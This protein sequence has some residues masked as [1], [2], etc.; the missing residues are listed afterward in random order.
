MAAHPD[1]D[2]GV[3]S[4][5]R[6]AAV[7]TRSL[8]RL[9][10]AIGMDDWV[11]LDH[12]EETS[13]GR[14]KASILANVFEA[15]LAALYLDGGL[16]PVRRLV[17][18]EF[19]ALIAEPA[20]ALRDAKT[21]LQET[22]QAAGCD[23]PPVPDDGRAGSAA[24]AR[25]PCRGHQRRPG[26]RPGGG[27]QQTRGGATRGA[28]RAHP[29]PGVGVLSADPAHRCGVVALLGRPNAG[30][31]TLLNA[32]L[33]EKLAITSA[34]AQTTRS[35]ILGVLTR[36]GVQMLFYDTPGVHRGQARFNL[37]MT[38]AALAA[39]EDAD[40][41]RTPVRD[42]GD[43]GYA[44]GAAGGALPPGAAGAHQ[45]RPGQA[46][47][48]P[49]AGALC[50]DPE[51][52]GTD[53]PRSAGAVRCN[54]RAPAA[55]SRPLSRRRADR[56]LHALPGGGADPRGRLRAA[57]RRDPLCARRRGG[58]VAGGGAGGAHT[59]E[60]AGGAGVAQGDRGRGRGGRML[61]AISAPRPGAASSDLS[62]ARPVH[63]NL[64]VKTDRNW[65]KRPKRI[66]ELGY[67]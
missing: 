63:L 28:R 4:R 23:A 62:S 40:V 2:E 38:D 26:D 55:R 52:L 30:K 37:A 51:R 14:S 29:L 22:L 18:T 43:L 8:A 7:N 66:R 35:R 1:V 41:P 5:A 24:R 58:R 46:Q 49:R 19:G 42:R 61:Q 47:A 10:R 34:A 67:L 15:L 60:P 44:R 50:A 16:E 39:A 57:T 33:G 11:L 59:R 53:R 32:L 45:V 3:L 25:V 12:G 17:E 54:R 9:A 13:G 48:S 65:S 27:A 31:S 36:P 6:A 64:W 21:R 56:S 20:A